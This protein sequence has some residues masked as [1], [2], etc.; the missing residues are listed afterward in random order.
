MSAR[1]TSQQSPHTPAPTLT[2][3][4]PPSPG[5]G[6]SLA[7]E[8]PR[9]EEP[10]C[11]PPTG[12][13]RGQRRRHD[14]PLQA[15]GHSQGLCVSQSQACCTRDCRQP[16]GRHRVTW[17][18]KGKGGKPTSPNNHSHALALST[19][20]SHGRSLLLLSVV[21]RHRDASRW[22]MQGSRPTHEARTHPHA[23]RRSERNHVDA[24]VVV[25]SLQ[26][27]SREYHNTI[28]VQFEEPYMYEPQSL[29]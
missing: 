17:T 2:S 23:A 13:S 15:G 18:R 7:E 5:H 22:S 4:A 14:S 19:H 9:G 26:L 12:D 8:A 27:H 21:A 6:G 28:A 20:V 1:E 10:V 3:Q 16:T 11:G 25:D 24:S 29:W